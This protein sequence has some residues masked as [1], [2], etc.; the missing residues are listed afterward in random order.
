MLTD[1]RRSVLKALIEEYIASGQ[2]VGSKHLVERHQLGCSPATVRNELVAL[3]ETG[4][5]YQ[6]HISSGRVPTDAG[7]RTFV[8]DLLAAGD[9]ASDDD[10]LAVRERYLDIVGEVD[11]LMRQTSTLLSH[12]THY[13]AVVVAPALNLSRIHRVNIVSMAP[14]RALIVVITES[15]EVVNRHVTFSTEAT[16]EL[17]AEME[18]ALNVALG[19]KRAAEVR[20]LRGRLDIGH[21]D[22]GLFTEVTQQVVECLEEAD[23]DRL[24]HVGVPELLALPE[25]SHS[26]MVRPLLTVLEDGLGMLETLSEVMRTRGITVRIG[27]ENRARELEQMSLVATRYG[28]ETSDGIVGVIGPTRMDYSRSIAAVHCAA[29]SL[30]EAL[31]GSA[32]RD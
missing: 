18:S 21:P 2:P 25:F 14:R 15:G 23:W 32:E 29:D 9:M 27:S 6:P 7:Y 8:D 17:L 20:P 31:G 1:R 3:E 5:V 28:S 19:G 10:T 22:H 11:E 12:L 26:S 4:Y 30:S 24:Y 13:V 16:P